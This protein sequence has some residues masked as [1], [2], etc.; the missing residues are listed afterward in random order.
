MVH[1]VALLA[2]VFYVVTVVCTLFVNRV[3]RGADIDGTRLEEHAIDLTKGTGHV[4]QQLIVSK[5]VAYRENNEGA[6]CRP[7]SC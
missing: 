4:L 7:A 2:Y 1:A 3:A 6:T 5:A